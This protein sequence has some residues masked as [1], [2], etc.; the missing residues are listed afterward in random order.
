LLAK[1]FNTAFSEDLGYKKKNVFS[2][3]LRI[4]I[5]AINVTLNNEC[6]YFVNKCN[7]SRIIIKEGGFKFNM[8]RFIDS[9]SNPKF[10][11]VFKGITPSNYSK[12]K[13][14]PLFDD[15]H[16][17]GASDASLLTHRPLKGQH[18]IAVKTKHDGVHFAIGNNVQLE[19]NIDKT[20]RCKISHDYN[21]I[22]AIHKMN[23]LLRHAEG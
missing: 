23:K 12:P 2:I 6:D 1:N 3:R 8:K 11:G 7:E 19:K 5:A 18:G 10:I 13:E 15:T 22:N 17:I 14:H 4:C 21:E 20:G 9:R 16:E